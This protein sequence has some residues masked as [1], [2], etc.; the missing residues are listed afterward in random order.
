M[1]LHR[2]GPQDMADKSEG[3]FARHAA[4]PGHC[5]RADEGPKVVILDEPTLGIDPEGVH[6]PFGLIKELS[7][8][9]RRTVLISS[10]QLYQAADLQSGRHIRERPA[11]GVW[12]HRLLR[13]ATRQRDIVR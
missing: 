8:K 10:H 4:A 6:E 3:V 9:D 5:G 11:G 13:E 1:L 7:E 2:V 12:Q